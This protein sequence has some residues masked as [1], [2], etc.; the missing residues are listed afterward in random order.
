MGKAQR[1]PRLLTAEQAATY[2]NFSLPTFKRICTVAPL[3][4]GEGKRALL[5]YDV[6]SLD[7]WIDRLNHPTTS[8][9]PLS[10]EEALKRMRLQHGR[11]GSRERH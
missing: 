3:R 7:E 6:R 4:F 2:C 11:S 9:D 10:P 1:E 5:R 8:S